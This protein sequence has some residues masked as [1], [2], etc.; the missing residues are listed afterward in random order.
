M[1]I[2]NT[3]LIIVILEL[4]AIA[5]SQWQL[6]PPTRATLRA[7]EVEERRELI[8][9][10]PLSAIHGSV[11]ATIADTISVEVSNFDELR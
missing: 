11:D 6:A 7:A 5:W 4:G 3:L 1:K 8:N 2:T 9:K 10:I